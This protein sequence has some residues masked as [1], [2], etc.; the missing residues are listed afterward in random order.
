MGWSWRINPA[1]RQLL[2]SATSL[3]S[4]TVS[5]QRC[6]DRV[7]CLAQIEG[8]RCPGPLKMDDPLRWCLGT[9]DGWAWLGMVGDRWGW[10][11][12]PG[13]NSQ[14][15]AGGSPPFFITMQ[16]PSKKRGSTHMKRVHFKPWYPLKWLLGS[17]PFMES[18]D[19][20]QQLHPNHPSVRARSG[21]FPWSRTFI[22]RP[23]FWHPDPLALIEKHGLESPWVAKGIVAGQ[24]RSMVYPW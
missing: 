15:D 22:Q 19:S 1:E 17:S 12:C 24:W 23:C 8:T 13:F 20:N 7:D 18:G 5:L 21:G 16:R 4:A 2:G 11:V 3:W 6:G 14:F 9:V 10:L